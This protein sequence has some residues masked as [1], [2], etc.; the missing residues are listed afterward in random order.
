MIKLLFFLMPGLCIG[1]NKESNLGKKCLSGKK[2][3]SANFNFRRG[4]QNVPFFPIFHLHPRLYRFVAKHGQKT[5]R[6]MG[7]KKHEEQDLFGR[8]DLGRTDNCTRGF[9]LY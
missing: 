9:R 8:L 5:L 7:K 6:S 2:T 1:A 3:N 4:K